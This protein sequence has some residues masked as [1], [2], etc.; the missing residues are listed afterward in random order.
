MKM[1]TMKTQ[2]FVPYQVQCI[3]SFLFIFNLAVDI[4]LHYTDEV[5]VAQQPVSP[6]ASV[7]K[8]YD[9]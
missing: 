6:K 7:E 5:D 2:S 3:F 4:H 9:R 8:V 1:V